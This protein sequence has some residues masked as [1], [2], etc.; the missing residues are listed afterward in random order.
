MFFELTTPNEQEP[1][2]PL[3]VEGP[4]FDDCEQDAPETSTNISEETAPAAVDVAAVADDVLTTIAA[5][6]DDVSAEEHDA[7]GD[8]E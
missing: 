7:T 4:E 6:C 5:D 8:V 3:D 1:D 2:I